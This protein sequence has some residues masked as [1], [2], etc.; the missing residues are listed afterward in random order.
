MKKSSEKIDYH[1]DWS[2]EDLVQEIVKDHDSKL[3]GQLYDRYSNK[4]Y[5][6]CYSFVKNRDEAKDLTHDIFLRAYLRI[7]AFDAAKASFSTWLYVITYNLCTN[8]VSRDLKDKQKET[9]LGKKE[10]KEKV[11]EDIDIEEINKLNPEKLAAA[12]DKIPTEDKALLLLKYQDDAP[13]KAIQELLGV[14]ESAVKMR[15]NRAKLK[16][17]KTY[18]SL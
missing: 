13:I 16:V 4:V 15:L 8:Y 17:V 12:L 1:K 7:H 18:N 14:G 11:S 5:N 3:Y 2:D 6:K 9:R 10:L